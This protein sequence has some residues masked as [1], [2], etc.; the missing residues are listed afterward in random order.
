MNHH[1]NSNEGIA[2]T[3]YHTHPLYGMP[4]WALIP[5]G[6]IYCCDPKPGWLSYQYQSQKSRTVTAYKPKVRHRRAI[7]QA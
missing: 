3:A 5:L 1:E 7:P 4:M 6:C 2:E